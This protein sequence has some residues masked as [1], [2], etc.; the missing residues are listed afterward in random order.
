M[1]LMTGA[2]TPTRPNRRDLMPSSV[3]WP[4]SGDVLRRSRLASLSFFDDLPGSHQP[5]GGNCYQSPPAWR[6]P[7]RV[8]A[9]ITPSGWPHFLTLRWSPNPKLARPI[10][11]SQPSALPLICMSCR[12]TAVPQHLLA[13]LCD[14]PSPASA[15]SARSHRSRLALASGD[16]PMLPP[17]R[18][19]T[20]VRGRLP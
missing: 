9:R 7:S 3:S 15:V 4:R 13:V 17:L 19:T 8:Y 16:M 20:P 11:P 5:C 10:H 18:S 12:A 2:A 6:Q 1:H 14:L